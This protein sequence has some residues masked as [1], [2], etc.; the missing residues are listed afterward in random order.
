MK[1]RRVKVLI[2][3]LGLFLVSGFVFG[4]GL[5]KPQAQ[6]KDSADKAASQ[7]QAAAADG[8]LDNEFRVGPGD[9]ILITVWKEPE[10][11]GSVVIRPDGK[12]SMPLVNDVLVNGMTPMQVQSLLAEKLEPYIKSANVTVTVQTIRSK[13]VYVIGQVGRAGSYDITQPTTVLQL[14]TEAGGPQQFAKQKSIYVLRNEGGKQQ[15]FKF[16]YKEV[17]NGKKIEQNIIVQPGDTI[18]VP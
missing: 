1:C 18:V 17:I 11:S 4:P 10:V 6:K 9:Q 3:L 13:K 7:R 14:L 12:I 2:G 8:N 5:T 15:K 16:N